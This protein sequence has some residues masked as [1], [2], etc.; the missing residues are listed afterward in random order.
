[1]SILQMSI[2]G[3][4]LIVG[5]MIFRTLFVN[6]LPKKIML[7]LWAVAMLRLLLPLSFT[8]DIPGIGTWTDLSELD[9]LI[10]G[11][12][13]DETDTFKSKEE[14]NTEIK[15]GSG[16]RTETM[17]PENIAEEKQVQS[18]QEIS[19]SEAYG[20][21]WLAGICITAIF[22]MKLYLRD[23]RLL[24]EAIPLPEELQGRIGTLLNNREA[25]NGKKRK[26]QMKLSDRLGT[27]LVYGIVRPV[28]VLPKAMLRVEKERMTL[29]VNHELVH[30]R[31]RDNLW[32]LIMLLTVCLHWFNPFVWMMY[33][34]FNRDMELACDEAVIR[35]QGT[36]SRKEYA[37]ALLALAEQKNMM[38]STGMAFGKNAVKER[39]EAIMKYRKL[40]IAGIVVATAV[41]T[42]SLTVFITSGGGSLFQKS[43]NSDT[44]NAA[45]SAGEYASEGSRT[46]GTAYTEI[47]QGSISYQNNENGSADVYMP[48]QTGESGD[49]MATQAAEIGKEVVESSKIYMPDYMKSMIQEKV[50]QYA[51]YG[52]TVSFTDTDFQLYYNG[53]KVCYF[54][55]NRLGNDSKNFKGIV[56]AH[57]PSE[58]HG[59]T[60]VVTD[61][62]EKGE[63]TGLLHLSE[64]ETKEYRNGRW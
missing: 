51:D 59:L 37:L 34:I 60:G 3:G 2:T 36:G 35:L 29:I 17:S 26:F 4:L 54:A 28:M 11:I 23:R 12:Q 8:A 7:C 1:M 32:K 20:R 13:S 5:I 56:Y 40:T 14:I 24:K 31:H 57:A 10:Y 64:Q 52:L 53:E 18:I 33:V 62:N 58:E 38:L 45:M 22:F 6:H 39:I 47:E 63:V 19:E 21:I 9:R 48:N 41:I 16:S 25:L 43:R 50:D 49:Y 55:D 30:I 15:K 44:G 61:Q 42:A 27:P 46:E